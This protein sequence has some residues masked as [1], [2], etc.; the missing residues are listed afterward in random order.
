MFSTYSTAFPPLL[1]IINLIVL[2]SQARKCLAA[3]SNKRISS[4]AVQG[5]YSG[6]IN[7]NRGVAT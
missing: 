6:A 3:G 5:L 4:T 1:L 2:D 7:G